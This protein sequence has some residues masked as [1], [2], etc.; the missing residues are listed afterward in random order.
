MLQLSAPAL[1]DTV[2]S[3][4]DAEA[5]CNAMGA[6]LLRP[7]SSEP[8][9][10]LKATRSEHFGD[11]NK[12]HKEFDE[13]VIAID[14]WYGTED[15]TTT[16]REFFYRD[17]TKVDPNV[18]TVFEWATNYP[19]ADMDHNCVALLNTKLVNVPCDDA[20]Y[21]STPGN[22]NAGSPVMGYIC[23]LRLIED[24]TGSGQTCHFPFV[25]QQVK[26]KRG[27]FTI[28][29]LSGPNSTITV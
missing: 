28:N 14:L 26:E 16:M 24:R 8:F 15:N 3:H 27:E 7:R 20:S 25:Y 10:H 9:R 19:T 2:T 6:R 1:S 22:L 23:E 5:K 13:T 21:F 12:Y 11:N 29:L 17:G 18:A 4:A